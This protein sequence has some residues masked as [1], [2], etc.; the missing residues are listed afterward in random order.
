MISFECRRGYFKA[1]LHTG[2]SGLLIDNKDLT[3][4]DLIVNKSVDTYGAVPFIN[5]TEN[6][7]KGL[8]VKRGLEILL[9]CTIQLMKFCHY[10]YT[11]LL[12]V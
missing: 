6:Y 4:P 1:V 7:Y 8:F 2:E 10:Q 9:R 11:K 12:S 3:I 5:A